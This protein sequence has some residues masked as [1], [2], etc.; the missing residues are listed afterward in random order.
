[1]VQ[2]VNPRVARENAPFPLAA[3]GIDADLFKAAL[4]WMAIGASGLAVGLALGVL[5]APRSGEETRERLAAS[6]NRLG[7][8]LQRVAEVKAGAA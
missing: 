7:E 3:L 4:L 6:V 5:F 8:E 2:P 1:M